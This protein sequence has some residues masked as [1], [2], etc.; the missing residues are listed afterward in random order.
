MK[1][2][3]KRRICACFCGALLL[4]SSPISAKAQD[5]PVLP[6]PFSVD[7]GGKGPAVS[8]RTVSETV[9]AA[10]NV[11]VRS[12]PASIYPVIGRIAKAEA[13]Y[14]GAVGDNGWSQILYE[15]QPAYVNTPHLS[16]T[17]VLD[18]PD[19]DE[20][21]VNFTACDDIRFSAYTTKLR[22]GPG[23]EYAVIGHLPTGTGTH[24]IAEGDNGWSRVI[25]HD[26]E[27][28][29]CTADLSPSRSRAP[30]DQIPPVYRDAPETLYASQD[31]RVRWGPGMGYDTAGLISQ[32]SAVERLALGSD[33][34]SRIDFEGQAAYVCT[35]YLSRNPEVRETP[36]ETSRPEIPTPDS[37]FIYQYMA[38]EGIMPH[39]LFRPSHKTGDKPLP[40][41]ISLH[42]ALEI[43]ESPDTLK[44]NFST[45]EIRNW[46]YSGL[47]GFD[48]YVV[49]PQL[50]G[51]GYGESWN[52][53]EIADKF[54]ALLD[55]LKAN[56]N[57][58]ESRI[59][60]EGHS[61][62]GQGAVYMAA[63]PRACFSAVVP[64]SA[65][66]PDVPYGHITAAVRGYTGSPYLPAPREDW[67]SFNYMTE[68]FTKYFG[69]ENLQVRSCSHY[70]IP[71]VAFHEDADGDGKSDLITW[72]LTR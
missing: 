49:C 61:L 18:Q 70:D 37:P 69:P 14:R 57:I 41:I 71:M 53:P 59:S 65:Y 32:G 9:Y 30:G 4:L 24:R 20:S 8:Y 42:G 33:G 38:P 58:D 63:D 34:W 13:V 19:Y 6:T 48:A 11:Y 72:M 43:G 35:A 16:V 27:A 36:I 15:G 17:P 22:V 26:T 51:Y 56:Y 23:F 67:T 50:T 40:L 10:R 66:H 52:T 1:N 12:G 2:H 68:M 62:G 47:S 5:S 60:I 44:S 28:Y 3:V 29:A 55:Y 31:V 21:I 46:E 45:K 39:A 25:F 7:T 64:V 54:F